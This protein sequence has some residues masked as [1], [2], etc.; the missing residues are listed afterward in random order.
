MIILYL[1]A[2]AWAK[3]Y[4]GEPGA[5][6]M[7]KVFDESTSGDQVELVSSA[8]SHAEAFSALVRFRNR[9]DM[10]SERFDRNLD[11]IRADSDKLSW[12]SVPE[13]AFRHCMQL[14]LRHGINATDAAHLWV[15]RDFR[16]M[17]QAAGHRVWLVSSDKRFL[18]AAQMEGLSCL[19]P[20]VSSLGEVRRLFG[21]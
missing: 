9:T 5:H 17:A 6:V 14:I 19:D 1:D 12:L 2:S 3:R 8:I 7:D 10:S 11:R 16:D 20:E 21:G 18:R 4:T 13:E 15:L